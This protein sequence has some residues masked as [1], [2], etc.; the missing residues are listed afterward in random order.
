M[1]RVE[2]ESDPLDWHC[3]QLIKELFKVVLVL[4]GDRCMDNRFAR[5]FPE[6]FHRAIK[7]P[8]P[9]YAVVDFP[10]SIEGQNPL[11]I[12]WSEALRSI[13]EE[14]VWSKILEAAS[15]ILGRSIGSPP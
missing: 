3:A 1:G 9:P 7:G 15:H 6:I 14:R 12:D 8:I 13:G 2:T 4:P 11:S 10:G 5:S